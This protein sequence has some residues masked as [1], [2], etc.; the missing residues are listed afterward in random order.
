LFSFTVWNQFW[1]FFSAFSVFAVKT[2]LQEQQ[3]ILHQIEAIGATMG[4]VSGGTLQHLKSAGFI[5]WDL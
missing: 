1:A 4:P 3:V 2:P 5:I